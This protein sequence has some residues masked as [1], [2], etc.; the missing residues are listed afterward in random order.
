MTAIASNREISTSTEREA[1]T[2]REKPIVRLV[3]ADG[4]SAVAIAVAIIVAVAEV[5]ALGLELGQ[6]AAQDVDM[7]HLQS[8]ERDP[9][10]SRLDGPRL[11]D[12]DHALHR[13]GDQ[14]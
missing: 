4:L 5:R 2:E 3:R 6:D 12:K 8:I 14:R 10:R 1:A 11:D 7:G 9:D 13:R